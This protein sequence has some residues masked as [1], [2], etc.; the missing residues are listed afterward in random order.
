MISGESLTLISPGLTSS[1]SLSDC[2]IRTV[3]CSNWDGCKETTQTSTQVKDML[4]GSSPQH[5]DYNDKR[6]F[7]S[8]CWDEKDSGK[9]CRRMWRTFSLDATTSSPSWWFPR[10]PQPSPPSPRGASH[11][12]VG[13]KHKHELITWSIQN[14]WTLSNR[15]D[16]SGNRDKTK[17][18]FLREN[19]NMI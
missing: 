2:S 4:R 13:T 7:F 11:L 3:H 14:K 6:Q 18:E 19:H 9:M 17:F 5:K 12:R 10:C 15:V 16:T 1:G 8:S